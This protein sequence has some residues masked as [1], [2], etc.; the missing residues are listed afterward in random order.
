MTDLPSVR[1]LPSGL[2]DLQAGAHLV[3]EDGSC[4]MEYVSVL[5]G[6]PFSDHPACTDPTLAE[7]ARLVNDAISDAG[8]GS[9]AHV[10][11]A[12]AISPP[13]TALRTALVVHAAVTVAH[14]TNDADRRLRR[15]LRRSSRRL[16]RV[17]GTGWSSALARRFDPLYRQGTARRRLAV[18]VAAIAKL[19]EQDRDAALRTALDAAMT[20]V[21]SVGPWG[22]SPV[23]RFGAGHPERCG[24]VEGP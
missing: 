5:A 23:R 15:H 7:L 16:E 20:A 11:P 9:L 21:P 8:R 19:P 6:A 4:L 2:P 12:L 3:P 17:T 14:T 10:A 18:C 13:T 22:G 1:P 24:S